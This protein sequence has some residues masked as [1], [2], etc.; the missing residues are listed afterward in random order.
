MV[1]RRNCDDTE[2]EFP[3]RPGADSSAYRRVEQDAASDTPDVAG[4]PQFLVT[5]ADRKH[6]QATFLLTKLFARPVTVGANTVLDRAVNGL[7][8]DGRVVG[9]DCSSFL[10]AKGTPHGGGY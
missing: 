6:R 8:F 10:L 7:R 9:G 4:V 5:I 1:G 2:G 3:R